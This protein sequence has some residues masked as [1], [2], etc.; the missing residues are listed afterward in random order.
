MIRDLAARTPGLAT[1]SHARPQEGEAAKR[2]LDAIIDS[3]SDLINL[4]VAI[5]K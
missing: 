2:T 4:R 5:M 3:A 1:C